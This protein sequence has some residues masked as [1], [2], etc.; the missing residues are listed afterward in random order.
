MGRVTVTVALALS[1]SF[2][3]H[4][5]TL[6]KQLFGAARVASEQRS[7]SFGGYARGCLAG[8]LQLPESG[9]T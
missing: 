3:A 6:A 7:A 1:L 9:A 8:A 2:P 4:A 5:E